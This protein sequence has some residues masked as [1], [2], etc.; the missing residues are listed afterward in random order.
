LSVASTRRAQRDTPRSAS[1]QSLLGALR[2]LGQAA[3]AS[4]AVSDQG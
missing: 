3:D 4:E 1:A 2:G